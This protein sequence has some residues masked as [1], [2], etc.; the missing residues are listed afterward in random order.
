MGRDFWETFQV[1]VVRDE[2]I[3]GVGVKVVG[4]GESPSL[5]PDRQGKHPRTEKCEKNSLHGALMTLVV[6]LVD[7]V[8]MLVDV[9]VR[10]RWAEEEAIV[11]NTSTMA[12]MRLNLFILLT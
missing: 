5:D 9:V 6:V 10:A 11:P 4:D 2:G 7:V 3:S 8:T 12:I 1:G